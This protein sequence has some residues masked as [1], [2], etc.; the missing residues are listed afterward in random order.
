[1]LGGQTALLNFRFST[2]PKPDPEKPEEKPAS[3]ADVLRG[4]LLGKH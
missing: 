3:R 4:L 2:D 1:M